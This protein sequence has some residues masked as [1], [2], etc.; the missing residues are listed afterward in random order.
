MRKHRLREFRRRPLNGFSR[1]PSTSDSEHKHNETFF[2]T[3]SDPCTDDANKSGDDHESSPESVEAAVRENLAE[4][5]KR[6]SDIGPNLRLRL[7]SDVR[8]P[9]SDLL[10][11]SVTA[12]RSYNECE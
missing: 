8:P 11:A 10:A 3:I 1:R 9:A 6:D 7:E 5:Q 4:Q 2:K 12:K